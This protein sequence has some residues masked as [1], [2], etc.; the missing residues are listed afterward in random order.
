MRPI[1][2]LNVHDTGDTAANA[3]TLSPF[4]M[5]QL[6]QS[7]GADES[8]KTTVTRNSFRGRIVQHQNTIYVL[9]NRSI[10]RMEANGSWTTLVSLSNWS[11]NTGQIDTTATMHLVQINGDYFLACIYPSSA[12]SPSTTVYVTAAK[13]DLQTGVTS[14]TSTSS[15]IVGSGGG[16]ANPSVLG[17]A[18]SIVFNGTVYWS[19]VS[20]AG[21]AIVV[22]NVSSNSIT[23]TNTALP[24]GS[25]GTGP[26]VSMCIYNNELWML[27]Y[28]SGTVA[29]IL[30][31]LVGTTFVSQVASL[32]GTTVA[33]STGVSKP[34]LFTDGTNMYA[35]ALRATG[36]WNAYQITSS[37][38]VTDITSNVLS[39]F[40]GQDLDSRWRVAID[41]HTDPT[42]PEIVLMFLGD[43]TASGPISFYRWNGPSSVPTFLGSAGTSNYL[44]FIANPLDGGG[45][46]MYTVGEPHAQIEGG[47]AASSSPGQTTISY[48][49]YESTL[50]PSGTP[51]HVRMYF[52]DNGMPA[53]NPCRLTNPQPGSMVDNYTVGNITAGSGILYS[54]DWRA[55]ADGV[56]DGTGVLLMAQV[57]GVL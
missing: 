41:Q 43:V 44:L 4:G 31:K 5:T 11:A 56:D 32:A 25:S 17:G 8:L 51:V 10:R 22:Y 54:I 50:I 24:L 53:T 48:R 9:Y 46:M 28:N 37:L 45:E 13:Y 16:G 35:F 19:L 7:L 21:N 39:T 49:I 52:S 26:T 42:N 3:Y 38:D 14:Y 57:S 6:G 20:G 30:Y 34:L 18:E 40:T 55:I 2:A 15:A 23:S 33:W 47:L 29:L 1:L 12:S 27:A 36:V